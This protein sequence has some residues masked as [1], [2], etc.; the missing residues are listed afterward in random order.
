MCYDESL[1]MCWAPASSGDRA[2]EP[3]QH[4]CG[5]ADSENHM[6]YRWQAMSKHKVGN[7]LLSDH[8]ILLGTLAR[9]LHQHSWKD[10]EPDFV[11]KYVSYQTGSSGSDW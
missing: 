5:D 10:I 9:D 7:T 2:A 11:L 6:G 1:L 3:Y 8:A 4:S